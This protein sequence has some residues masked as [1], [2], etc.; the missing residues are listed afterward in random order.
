MEADVNPKKKSP[1]IIKGIKYLAFTGIGGNN[2][3]NLEFG[4]IN[5]NATKTP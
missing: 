3:I 2:N 1:K 4:N 5:V